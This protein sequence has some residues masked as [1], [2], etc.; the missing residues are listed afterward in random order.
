MI[1]TAANDVQYTEQWISSHANC[2]IQKH[3]KAT[4]AE[5]EM[6]KGVYGPPPFKKK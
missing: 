2:S 4:K 3:V 6:L 1:D 5:V